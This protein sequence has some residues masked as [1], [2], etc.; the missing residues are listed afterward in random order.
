MNRRDALKIEIMHEGG[1]IMSQMIKAIV[2]AINPGVTTAQ[3]NDLA[4]E[5]C[6]KYHVRPA[7]LGFNGYPASLCTSVNDVV[8]HGI[9]NNKPLHEGDLVGVDFGIVYKGYC[10]DCARSKYLGQ[11]SSE[12]AKLL[13]VTEDSLKAAAAAIRPNQSRVG[14]IGATVEAMAKEN[15]LGVVRDLAG[16]GIGKSLQEDPSI[17]NYGKKN[18]G[19]LLTTGMTIA[20]EPMLTLGT[21]EV[22][23]QRDGWGV[24]TKDKSLSAHFEDTFAIMDD[25]IVNLTK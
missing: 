23:M 18:T 7:F 21:H 6:Q 9:P 3:L 12:I 22:Y 8:V 24:N 11:P 16:H 15:G 5:L 25:K 13:R 4:N 10:L 17:P 19:K 14:D 2:N 20:I 1:K